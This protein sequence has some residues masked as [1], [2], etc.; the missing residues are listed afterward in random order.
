VVGLHLLTF[1]GVILGGDF[2]DVLEGVLKERVQ[3]D[4]S[5]ATLRDV[6]VILDALASAPNEKSQTAIIRD[7]VIN[8]FNATEQKWLARI[9]YRELKI[10]TSSK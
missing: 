9:I 7:R 2:S 4:Y 10:G 8:R 5:N 6:H 1:Q 3:T